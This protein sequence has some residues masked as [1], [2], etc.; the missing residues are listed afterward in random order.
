MGYF[1]ISE[2]ETAVSA[3]SPASPKTHTPLPRLQERGHRFYSANLSRW[4]SRD[5]AGEDAGLNLFAFVLND[6]VRFVDADGR[7]IFPIIIIPPSGPNWPSYCRDCAPARVNARIRQQEDIVR[8]ITALLARGSDV[9]PFDVSAYAR[10]GWRSPEEL[11]DPACVRSCV[12]DIE[13]TGPL[14]VSC[15]DWFIRGFGRMER[16]R[17]E[18]FI[19][20]MRRMLER[21]AGCPQDTRA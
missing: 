16:S 18:R 3:Q 17:S 2:A 21:C 19:R 1:L 8:Q 15:C 9:C 6:P 10:G 7:F 5:P 20:C 12:D 11:A 13:S 14:V 4:V